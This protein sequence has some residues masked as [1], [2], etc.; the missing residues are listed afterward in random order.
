M[1]PSIQD[2]EIDTQPPAATAAEEMEVEKPFQTTSIVVEPIALAHN[3]PLGQFG[4]WEIF[5]AEEATIE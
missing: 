1:T 5:R 2:M 3:P 4:I